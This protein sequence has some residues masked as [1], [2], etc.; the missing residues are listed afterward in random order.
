MSYLLV[1]LAG[2]LTPIAASL[3]LLV[4]WQAIELLRDPRHMV[5]QRPK[6]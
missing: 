2:V 4:M 6:P 5:Y 1:Y 3:V